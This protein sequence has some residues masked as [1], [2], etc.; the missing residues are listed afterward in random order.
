MSNYL[1][2]FAESRSGSNWLVETLNNHPAVSLMK[3]ILQYDQRNKYYKEQKLEIEYFRPGND[4]EYL[5]QRLGNMKKEW[6]GCKILFPQIRFFDFYDFLNHFQNA[7]FI[8]LERQ[9]SV[10][11]ELSGCIAKTHGRWHEMKN[12]GDLLRVHIDPECFYR[13]LEWRRLSKE[14]VIN[15]LTAYKVKRINLIYEELFKDKLTVLN[16]I[17]EFLDVESV[18]VEYSKEKPANPYPLKEII[19]NY[20]KIEVFFRDHPFY[21]EMIESEAQEYT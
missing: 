16:K 3:E 4:V 21:H 6:A 15:I 11:A 2:I 18:E 9:N 1:F 17:W 7:L 12:P 19:K 10:R 14:F 20:K 8:I 13:R 5:K